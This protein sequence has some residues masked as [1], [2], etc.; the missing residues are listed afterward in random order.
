MQHKKKISD[1][2]STC[3]QKED[4]EWNWKYQKRSVAH[5]LAGWFVN[6]QEFSQVDRSTRAE[7]DVAQSKQVCTVFMNQWAANGEKQL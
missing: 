1:H 3:T 7:A 6:F 4:K 2:A 5:K